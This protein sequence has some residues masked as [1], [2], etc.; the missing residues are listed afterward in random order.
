MDGEAYF[1]AATSRVHLAAD[2]LAER[3]ERRADG[4]LVTLCWQVA[5]PQHALK[6]ARPR[7]YLLMLE[8][9][10]ADGGDGGAGACHIDVS[11]P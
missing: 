10:G 6:L 1:R 2:D 8:H 11:T 3:L 9:G 5:E 7:R 4:R